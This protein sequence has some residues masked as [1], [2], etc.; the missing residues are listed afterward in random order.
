MS[1]PAE[2]PQTQL[3]IDQAILAEL[4]EIMGPETFGAAFASFVADL[5]ASRRA[6]DVAA[7]TGDLAAIRRNAHR[8]KGILSQFGVPGA[9]AFAHQV[10]TAEETALRDLGER[11]CALL[12]GAIGEVRRVADMLVSRM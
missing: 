1:A 12:P 2:A 11:L 3:A 9:A 5:D 4:V 10:E 7:A 8:I 6:M